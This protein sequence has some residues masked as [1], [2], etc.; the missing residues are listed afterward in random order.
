MAQNIYTGL[1]GVSLLSFP[2]LS[3]FLSFFSSFFFF[4]FVLSYTLFFLMGVCFKFNETQIVSECSN[5]VFIFYRMTCFCWKTFC[6]NKIVLLTNGADESTVTTYKPLNSLSSEYMHK[7]K[8]KKL[9]RLM[10]AKYQLTL[11]RDSYN[12]KSENLCL[13]F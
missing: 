6:L 12:L 4:F 10:L 8:K 7:I 5:Y 3:F 1:E 13:P 11:R 9:I 2:F